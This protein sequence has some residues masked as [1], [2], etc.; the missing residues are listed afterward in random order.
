M[1]RHVEKQR[2][3]THFPTFFPRSDTCAPYYLPPG[4]IAASGPANVVTEDITNVG[5]MGGFCYCPDGTAYQVGH[6][7]NQCESLACVGGDPGDCSPQSDYSYSGGYRGSYTQTQSDAW[8]YKKVVCAP[9]APVP[10]ALL[11]DLGN[12]SVFLPKY[13]G[14]PYTNAVGVLFA[15]GAPWP[16]TWPEPFSTGARTKYALS[17]DVEINFSI[18][19]D[20]ECS[21]HWVAIS[22]DPDFKLQGFDMWS[23][24]ASATPTYMFLWSCSSRHL[25]SGAAV[26]MMGGGTS[27]AYDN[28]CNAKKRYDGI[29]ITFNGSVATWLVPGCAGQTSNYMEVGESSSVNS[30]T[31][32]CNFCTQ[33]TPYQRN[34]ISGTSYQYVPSPDGFAFTF[35]EIHS[36]AQKL[37]KQSIAQ[38]SLSSTSGSY[39]ASK[40]I[41]GDILPANAGIRG[42]RSMCH[43]A[44]GS[45]AWIKLDLGTAVSVALVKIYNRADTGRERFG[46]HVIETSL[47][48]LAWKT[49]GTYTLPSSNGP[50]DES[51]EVESARYVRLR[52]THEGTLNL[53]EV[54]IYSKS[55]PG[56]TATSGGWDTDLWVRCATDRLSVPLKGF[57]KNKY[58]IHV[59][60]EP[61][62]TNLEEEGGDRDSVVWPRSSKEVGVFLCY[63]SSSYS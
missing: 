4:A 21:N 23:M 28:T 49:C 31:F 27:S 1:K 52:K 46:E 47:D 44:G 24:V 53:G 42:T 25:F 56:G 10:M 32:P 15:R 35:S 59:G 5:E 51:C 62:R 34:A 11:G 13:D 30:K 41:D 18:L 60:A 54:E 39:T 2:P 57:D 6:N 16:R 3:H 55:L 19:K 33:C 63:A 8:K 20:E 40:C 17:G 45:K 7:K 37:V 38:A 58:Y 50:Y 36:T 29:K 22:E 43:S 26:G 14:T 61:V 12:P 48:D 9:V